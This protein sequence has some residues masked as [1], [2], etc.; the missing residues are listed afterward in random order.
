MQALTNFNIYLSTAT[1][2]VL[3]FL[4]CFKLSTALAFLETGLVSNALRT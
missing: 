3:K 1:S 4:L 2:V